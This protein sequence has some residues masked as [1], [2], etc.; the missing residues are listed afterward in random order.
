M[1]EF[2]SRFLISDWMGCRHLAL[3]VTGTGIE[4][5]LVSD[6]CQTRKEGRCG[7]GDVFPSPLLPLFFSSVPTIPQILVS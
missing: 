4:R 5:D 1:V 2:D 6:T 3:K 7:E